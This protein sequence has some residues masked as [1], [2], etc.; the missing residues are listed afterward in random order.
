MQLNNRYFSI[1]IFSLLLQ[2]KQQMKNLKLYKVK[3][4]G[5]YNCNFPFI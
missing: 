5:I 2:K 4:L 3:I 1:L